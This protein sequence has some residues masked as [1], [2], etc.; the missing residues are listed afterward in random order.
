MPIKT[1]KIGALWNISLE[2]D[3]LMDIPLKQLKLFQ[4]L[5]ITAEY[6]QYL[7]SIFYG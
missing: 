2:N 1:H 4:F 3:S 6:K 5:P 7:L